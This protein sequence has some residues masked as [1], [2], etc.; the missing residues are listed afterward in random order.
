M[1]C[2]ELCPG[3]V[4][5]STQI[6]HSTNGWPGTYEHQTECTPSSLSLL[7]LSSSP[8]SSLKRGQNCYSFH[9]CFC[10]S[11][12][13]TR[14]RCRLLE[15]T[16]RQMSLLS[17]DTLFVV[18]GRFCCPRPPR[19]KRVSIW[20]KGFPSKENFCFDYDLQRLSYCI[21]RLPVKF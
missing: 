10:L 11:L 13:F 2:L 5:L 7:V 4:P 3:L 16:K 6:V 19:G 18:W 9:H 14:R 12:F 20:S 1:R 21:E 17:V 8:C 15:S